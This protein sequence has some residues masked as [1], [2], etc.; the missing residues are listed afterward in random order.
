MTITNKGKWRK[1]ERGEGEGV[2]DLI[3]LLFFFYYYYYHYY[4]Y[5]DYR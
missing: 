3:S 4:H 2:K 1:E 5:C